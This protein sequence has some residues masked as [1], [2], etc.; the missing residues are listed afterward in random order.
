[1]R[2]IFI[3][4]GIVV[5]VGFCAWAA[6]LWLDHARTPRL[7]Q[8]PVSVVEEFAPGAQAPDFSFTDINGKN[9]DLRGFQGKKIILNFWASWCAPCIVEF[10]ELLRLAAENQKDTVFIALSS[11]ID[12]EA[13]L[14]FLEKVDYQ[15]SNIFIALD[16]NGAITRG[17]YKTY[18]LP[19]TV[20]IDAEGRTQHRL[21]GADWSTAEAAKILERL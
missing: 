4:A 14:R 12:K 19:E 7:I 16:E 9:H 6:T 21:I 10:P 2:N 5:A 3:N 11:D 18:K 20:L 13:M 8:A 1:M 15:K 17:L